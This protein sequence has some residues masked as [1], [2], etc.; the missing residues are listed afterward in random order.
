MS[1]VKSDNEIYSLKSLF[2]N[3]SATIKPY[4]NK[5]KVIKIDLEYEFINFDQ[6]IHNLIFKQYTKL[7]KIIAQIYLI[8]KCNYYGN[9]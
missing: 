3:G 4:F 9:K 2:K 7:E 8:K 1:K 6:N 5:N